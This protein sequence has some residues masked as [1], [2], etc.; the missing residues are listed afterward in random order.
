MVVS[1]RKEGMARGDKWSQWLPSGVS[2]T[3]CWAHQCYLMECK[4][5]PAHMP[6]HIHSHA[7]QCA[8][9]SNG[10][11]HRTLISVDI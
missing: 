9:T 1:R 5:A 2:H 6:I 10:K 7:H 8:L 11:P 4:Y 3:V